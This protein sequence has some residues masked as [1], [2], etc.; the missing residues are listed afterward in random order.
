AYSVAVG[1]FNRDGITDLAVA[2]YLSNTV[3]VLLGN[4]A[5]GFGPAT[6]FATDI[7]PIWVAI[8]DFNRDGNSDLAVA[9]QTNNDVSILLG[10]GAGGFAAHTDFAV[11]TQPISVAVGDF[12]GRL[13]QR[14]QSRPRCG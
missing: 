11:G 5:G 7:R 10:N 9:A 6:S 8:G 3:S 1:D 2:N 12:S 13:Q 14:R 4:G